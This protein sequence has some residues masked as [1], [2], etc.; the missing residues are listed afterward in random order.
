MMFAPNAKILDRYAAGIDAFEKYLASEWPAFAAAKPVVPALP[1]LQWGFLS[2]DGRPLAARATPPQALVVPL[3]FDNLGALSA[4]REAVDHHPVPSLLGIGADL[5]LTSIDLQT[6]WCPNE[7]ANPIFGRRQAA[8]GLIGADYLKLKHLTGRNVNIV[9][10][11]QGVDANLI[12]LRNFGGGWTI[13]G[14]PPGTTRGG[15]GAM[16]VRN[17]R[18]IAADATIYD[19]PVIPPRIA[20]IQNFLH[21]AEAAYHRMLTDIAGWRRAGRRR[22]PWIFVNAWAVSD[23]RSEQPPGDYTGNPRH[24]F[25]VMIEQTT[26]AGFD[27]V[28]GAGNGGQFCP[29]IRCG[30]QDR[31]PGNSIFGANSHASVLTMGAVRCDAMWLGYSSQGPGQPNLDHQKPDICG[32]SQF[33]EDDDAYLTNT[34]TSAATAV[35]AGVVAALRQ[36]WG[37]AIVSFNDLKRVLIL[38]ARRTGSSQWDERFGNGI[39]NAK[40]AYDLANFLYP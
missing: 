11:D 2:R 5:S 28:F 33:A 9:V 17:I 19:C 20:N 34:G 26:A 13:G 29:D 39:L 35:T 6:H 16:L 32:P 27:F 24:P 4:F 40:A 12:P 23:R 36:R 21:D 15:H 14:T 31:G 10:V 37:S 22:G 8:L 30:P 3:L 1:S 25:N 18:A 7:A 38:S